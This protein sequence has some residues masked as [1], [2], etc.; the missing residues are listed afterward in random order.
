M[1]SERSMRRDW[2]RQVAMGLGRQLTKQ[3]AKL[4]AAAWSAYNQTLRATHDV[5]AALAATTL[6]REWVVRFSTNKEV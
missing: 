2:Q 1:N 3:E 5:K 6:P 4:V